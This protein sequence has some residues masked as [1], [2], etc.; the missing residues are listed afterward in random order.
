VR[1]HDV[2]QADVAELMAAGEH[3]PVIQNRLSR[4]V[5]VDAAFSQRTMDHTDD[6]IVAAITPK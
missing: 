3:L 5:D 2:R 1:F 6:S 4:R